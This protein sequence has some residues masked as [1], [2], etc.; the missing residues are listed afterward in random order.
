[1][2]HASAM[3]TDDFEATTRS[4]GC[5]SALLPQ[6]MRDSATAVSAWYRTNSKGKAACDSAESYRTNSKGKAAC[7]SAESPDSIFEVCEKSTLVAT[8]PVDKLEAWAEMKR[9][10]QF[11]HGCPAARSSSERALCAPA[12]QSPRDFKD[13]SQSEKA[14]RELAPWEVY[15]ASMAR[16]E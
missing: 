2:V 9:R 6:R 14:V 3:H 15:V 7:D 1:M 11:A 8:P 5:A 4:V 12:R 13:A 10:Y 16:Q